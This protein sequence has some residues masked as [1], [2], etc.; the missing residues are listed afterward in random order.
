MYS[1]TENEIDIAELA[2]TK[3]IRKLPD[4]DEY[5]RCKEMEAIKSLL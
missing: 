1:R 3:G 5:L 2:K 4:I